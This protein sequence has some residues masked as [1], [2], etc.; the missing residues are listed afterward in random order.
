MLEPREQQTIAQTL[1]GIVSN[2]C[3]A[4]SLSPAS[5]A[6]QMFL[7]W[8]SWGFASLHPR[9]YAAAALRGLLTLSAAAA[10]RAPVTYEPAEQATDLRVL[11]AANKCLT[12]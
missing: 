10:L 11:R 6:L 7:H 4:Q 3:V 12:S 2:F 5:R 8:W 9:L 1:S